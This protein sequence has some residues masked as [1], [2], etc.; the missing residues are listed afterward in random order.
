MKQTGKSN[1]FLGKPYQK[2]SIRR[3]NVGVASVLLASGAFLTVTNPADVSADQ[4]ETASQGMPI[5]KVAPTNETITKAPMTETATKIELSSS[6][7]RTEPVANEAS[8]LVT[9]KMSTSN[10]TNPGVAASVA[11]TANTMVAENP[12]TLDKPAAIMAANTSATEDQVKQS[13]TENTQ[14]QIDVPAKYLT[15]ANY[16]GPFTAGVNQVIPYEAFGG[17]GML[18]RLLLKASQGAPWSDN[19]SAKNAALLPVDNLETGKYF[20][21]VSLDGEIGKLQDQALLD[22]LKKNGS[23]TYKAMIKV[24]G[25]KDGKVDLS[26]MIG[27]KAVS[28]QLNKEMATKDRVK[29]SVTENT[30]DQIDVPAK[31]LT[32]ANYPGP[33]TAGVNQVIP[34]EAFGGDGMLTRLL[35]KASQGAPWS[36]N[37]SAKNAALLPVDNLETG[38]YFYQVSLDGEIGKLQDQVLLDQ[39]K[40]NGTMTYKAMIKVYGSKDGKVDLSNMIGERKLPLL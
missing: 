18:T 6:E 11:D 40:K 39:L 31:Y 9:E 20:Y 25:S 23:M 30:Q 16:P 29:Q 28:I 38:K 3:L 24:Y 14:D 4:V 32:N 21:Q 19:G 8:T 17:D 13:V 27:E 22:Q 33:F 34:Y 12:Q 7:N 15:N 26:N 37:G 1:P 10:Q 36:D 5:S 35:L 2:W